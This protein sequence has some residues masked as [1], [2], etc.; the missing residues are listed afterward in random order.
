MNKEARFKYALISILML[1]LFN[2]PL[3]GTANKLKYVHNAPLLYLYIL[4]VWLIAILLLGI[5]VI[6]NRK[7]S[8]IK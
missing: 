2:Y 5:M 4:V 6:R 8:K 7:S 1:M 3:L